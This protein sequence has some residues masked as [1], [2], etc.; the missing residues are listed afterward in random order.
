[1]YVSCT[2][3]SALRSRTWL[4]RWLLVRTPRCVCKTDSSFVHWETRDTTGPFKASWMPAMRCSPKPSFLE[5]R[6]PVGMKVETLEICCWCLH[7]LCC[8][9]SCFCLLETR[10]K[11]LASFSV[12]EVGESV[13]RAMRADFEAPDSQRAPLPERFPL[14]HRG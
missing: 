4:D 1:M 10:S 14:T 13:L 3:F 6:S 12:V 5:C 9:F 11:S 8:A 2:C 7:W